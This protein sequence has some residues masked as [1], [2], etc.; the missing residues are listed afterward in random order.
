MNCCFKSIFALS[1]LFP[2]PGVL[3]KHTQLSTPASKK[4]QRMTNKPRPCHPENITCSYRTCSYRRMLFVLQNFRPLSAFDKLS[5]VFKTEP[6]AAWCWGEVNGAGRVDQNMIRWYWNDMLVDF[7]LLSIANRCL[8]A[9]EVIFDIMLRYVDVPMLIYVHF[10]ILIY[11]ELRYMLNH[12]RVFTSPIS[13]DKAI[14]GH[15]PPPPDTTTIV[16]SPPWN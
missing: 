7:F 1:G 12:P 16:G 15:F 8:G 2:G 4:H 3:L 11:V 10:P 5:A 13:G 9:S 6:E 14:S